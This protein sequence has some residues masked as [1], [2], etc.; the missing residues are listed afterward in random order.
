MTAMESTESIEAVADEMESGAGVDSAAADA[1]PVDVDSATAGAGLVDL[2]STTAGAGPVDVDSAA[3]DARYE[4]V[5]TVAARWSRIAFSAE[6]VNRAAAVNAVTALYE[7]ATGSEPREIIWCA[8][9]AEAA[10][11]VSAGGERFGASLREKL[12]T[13]PWQR[14]RAELM[15][16]LGREAWTA[17]WQA[18]CA[19]L[20]PTVSRLTEQIANAVASQARDLAEQTKLRLAL[21]FADQGQH[22]AAWLPLFEPYFRP[23]AD[24]ADV[25][26]TSKLSDAPILEALAAVAEQV[27]WWWAFENVAIL[28]ERPTELHLDERGRLHNGDG[29]ALAYADGFALHRWRGV[30]I[31]AEFAQTLAALT[32]DVIRGE[33]NAELRRI[34]L[35]HYGTERYIVDSGAQPMQEDAAG[36]LWRVSIPGD[37]AIVMVEVINS[38][39]EPDG[40]FNKYWLRVPPHIRTAKA[41]VAWTF[42]LS[43][44]EYEPAVQT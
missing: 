19:E 40:T 12:R 28:C 11:L 10:R 42:G 23:A 3:A 6:P 4:E 34:M 22:N 32:V 35:E 21:T 31:P 27:H 37:E 24:A 7:I 16:Q 26:A 33:R 14:A 18:T 1:R 43:E 30:T 5:E 17:A 41:A 2:D 39:A 8:S 20:A 36:K 13:E 29:P 44:E 25:A 38:T 15:E 9:P